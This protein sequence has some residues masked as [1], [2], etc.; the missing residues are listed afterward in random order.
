MAA[1]VEIMYWEL[2]RLNCS[3]I[4]RA[5]PLRRGRGKACKYDGTGKKKQKKKRLP[6]FDP[7]NDLC[8]LPGLLEFI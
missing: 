1:M 6:H 7:Q 8:S 4:D 5:L 3:A 2:G